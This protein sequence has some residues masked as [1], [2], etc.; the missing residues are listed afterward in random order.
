MVLYLT[1]NPQK[2]HLLKMI[3][4]YQR[5]LLFG[6]ETAWFKKGTEKTFDKHL[7]SSKL[8]KI[9]NRNI[10]KFNYSFAENILHIIKMTIE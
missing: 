3:K 5:S 10:L 7:K 4:H 9:F 8:H 6:K 2:S 1:K